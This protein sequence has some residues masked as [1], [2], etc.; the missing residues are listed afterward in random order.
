MIKHI[1]MAARKAGLAPGTLINAEEEGSTDT[2]I[3]IMNYD[4]QSCFEADIQA[5]EELACFRNKPTITWIQVTGRN[6]VS[7]LE[8]VG[9]CFGIHDLVLEDIH[10]T[11]HRPKMEDYGEYL[12]LIMK[13]LREHQGE[14]VIEQVS[15][16]LGKNYVISFQESEFDIFDPV[17]RRIRSGKGK[18][19]KAGPDYLAYAL[20]D[21]VVDNYFIVLE[22]LGEQVESLEDEVILNP[23]NTI[24]RKIQS[25][26]TEL[27]FIRKSVWPLREVISSL[28][29][30]ESDL[31]QG[32]TLIYIRDVYD[33]TIQVIDT[34]ETYRDMMSGLLDIYLSSISNRMNEVMKVLTII[35]TIFIPLTFLA[36]V[37]G[38][39]FKYMPELEW[40][41]GYPALL[42]LMAIIVLCM[43]Q[44][45]RRKKWI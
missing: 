33:H 45:F 9:H 20:L 11:G 7:I 6:N 16:I 29:R 36:G 5:V 37:E 21:I 18:I 13:I 26:K 28:E 35:A 19:R 40:E 15:L 4:E 34:V 17:R 8:K 44:F 39:N 10:N 1:K 41:W 3:S 42:L 43:I 12:F 30:G 14:T 22:H 27:L 2:C 24:I 25:L 23:N 31:F 38:M 32:T